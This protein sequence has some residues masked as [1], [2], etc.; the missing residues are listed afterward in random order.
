MSQIDDHIVCEEWLPIKLLWINHI[1]CEEWLPIKLLWIKGTIQLLR[2][3][4]MVP[5]AGPLTGLLTH[6]SP[7]ERQRRDPLVFTETEH[8][9]ATAADGGARPRA[10]ADFQ[11]HHVLQFYNPDTP[12]PCPPGPRKG[13]VSL[14][15]SPIKYVGF[16]DFNLHL[17]LCNSKI[18][19]LGCTYLRISDFSLTPLL[20]H[21][22][23]AWTCPLNSIQLTS[24]LTQLRF[25]I[26]GRGRW[27]GMCI[28]DGGGAST[29]AT[30]TTVTR[31]D[32]EGFRCPPPLSHHQTLQ[33][34]DGSLRSRRRCND[35]V[36]VAAVDARPPSSLHIPRH[37]CRRRC[38]LPS[39]LDLN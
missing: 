10:A 36:A 4:V 37:R 39:I 9:N 8:G 3:R 18:H 13:S 14:R 24:Y 12:R 35:R 38:T 28:H 1:V 32:S 15:N 2:M 7:I 17:L 33:L 25:K 20:F 34:L 21:P 23:L 11:D 29:A 16:Y 30:S 27:R 6:F 19:A 5:T 31:R 26:G 22:P